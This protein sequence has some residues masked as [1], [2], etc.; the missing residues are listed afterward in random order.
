[1]KKASPKKRTTWYKTTVATVVLLI[2]FAPLGIFTMWKYMQ[3]N[4]TIKWILTGVFALFFLLRFANTNYQQT[5]TIKQTG[6]VIRITPT[7]EKKSAAQGTKKPTPEPT[8]DCSQSA[9]SDMCIRMEINREPKLNATT[10]FSNAGLV[11]TNNDSIDWRLCT[12]T[13]G[14]SENINTAY[15]VS[16]WDIRFPANQT[17]TVPWSDFTQNDGNRFNYYTTKPNDIELDCSVNHQQEHLRI[18]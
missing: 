12:V 7:T 18:N 6:T 17:T 1:M 4:K 16:G 5:D 14:S 10:G 8:E 3:W 13:I 2:L 11:V 15:E 9:N